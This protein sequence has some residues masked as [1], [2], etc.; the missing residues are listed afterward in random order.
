MLEGKFR[1]PNV[2]GDALPSFSRQQSL[3]EVNAALYKAKNTLPL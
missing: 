1:E 3:A 2:Y